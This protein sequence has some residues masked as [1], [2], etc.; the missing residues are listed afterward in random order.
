MNKSP[1]KNGSDNVPGTRGSTGN[2]RLELNQQTR[3]AML[4][5][6]RQTQETIEPIEGDMRN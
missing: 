5:R 6:N 3:K 1:K 2:L 4:E